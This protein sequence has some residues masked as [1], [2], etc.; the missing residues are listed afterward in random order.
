MA[1]KGDTIRFKVAFR[2]YD[3]NIVKLV[4]DSVTFKLYNDKEE[5]VYT[6]ELTNSDK[7]NVGEY[8]HDLTLT[9]EY[10]KG[11]YTYEFN[12]VFNSVPYVSRDEI[13]LDFS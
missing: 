2:D 5:V 4:P 13:R 7:L 1:I 8:K 11:I 10:D 12:G 3:G 6:G 9:D